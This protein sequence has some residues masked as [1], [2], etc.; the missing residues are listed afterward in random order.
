VKKDRITIQQAIDLLAE[1]P[2]DYFRLS[3][4]KGRLATGYD[5][6]FVLMNLWTEQKISSASMHSKGKYTP[7]EG[8][9]FSARVEKTFLRGQQLLDGQD[10]QL[11][12]FGY[13]RWIR[14]E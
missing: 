8:A 1:N 11:E 7:F 3:P 14:P 2:A 9:T 10:K 6:D 4:R 12:E 5:A 13:G